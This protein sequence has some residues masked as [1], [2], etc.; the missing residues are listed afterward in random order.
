MAKTIF[1][2]VA[3]ILALTAPALAQD[4]Q[5][6]FQAA[7]SEACMLEDRQAAAEYYPDENWTL[8]WEDEYTYMERSIELH[9]FF[10]SSGAYNVNLV[11]YVIDPVD[12]PMP[13]SFAVPDFD[14][15]YVDDDL[16]GAVESI[17]LQGFRTQSMLTNPTF[18]PETQTITDHVLWRGIGDASSSGS[19]V[20]SRGGFVLKSYEV[21]ASYDGEINPKR[22]VNYP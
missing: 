15:R 20:W 3:G 7:F 11:F 16:D 13:V 4:A 5:A 14:V 18:D 21:D 2:S 1:A 12:G 6:A 22:I 10:C 19:W 9:Q 8:T 17:D